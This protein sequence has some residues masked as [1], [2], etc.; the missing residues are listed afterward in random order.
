MV[1]LVSRKAPVQVLAQS[2]VGV[3]HTGDLNETTL[4]TVTIPAGA[5]GA[6][7]QVEIWTLWAF[8]GSN[9]KTARVKFGGT[10]YASAAPTT[11]ASGH[12]VSRIGNRNATN[13]QVGPVSV[14]TSTSS[15][16]PVTSAVDTTAA[17]NIEIT[18]QLAAAGDSI[19]LESYLITI[20]PKA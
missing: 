17:V 10:T 3:T 12:L 20:I 11:H 7:G 13:S 14:G 1:G 5:M 4:A 2:A 6:N 18:G 15:L 16:A 8:T 9:T 19:T